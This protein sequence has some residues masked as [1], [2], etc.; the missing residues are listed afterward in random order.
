MQ[1]WLIVDENDERTGSMAH[2][3][4]PPSPLLLS[5]NLVMGATIRTSLSALTSCRE[6]INDDIKTQLM[7]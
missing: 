4:V 6:A 1:N 3:M 2:G 7:T 5:K